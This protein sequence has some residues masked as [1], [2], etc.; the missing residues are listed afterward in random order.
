M[1]NPTAQV[2]LYE[3]GARF[4]TKVK[5]SGGGRCNVTH[6]C[7][8][9]KLLASHYPRGER[10]LRAAF[11]RWQPQDTLNWFA[12][13]R[14]T[15][16]LPRANQSHALRSGSVVD[17]Q[18]VLHIGAGAFLEQFV[19]GLE[20][21]EDLLVVGVVE[22]AASVQAISSPQPAQSAQN[23]MSITKSYLHLLNQ[24]GEAFVIDPYES[25]RDKV[26][27]EDEHDQ[28]RQNDS[29]GNKLHTENFHNGLRETI[30]HA[31][32]RNKNASGQG[33]CR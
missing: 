30:Q 8:D 15:L 5:I 10:E 14:N 23:L 25:V 1:A 2:T 12:R 9:P 24:R 7:Y 27:V 16:F 33:N 32:H 22:G 17:Q 4:L 13:G 6:N 28:R 20:R 21:L 19:D 26:K 3:R 31:M 11:H 18:E 29:K